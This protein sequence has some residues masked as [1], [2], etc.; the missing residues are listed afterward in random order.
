MGAVVESK[1]NDIH[2]PMVSK[3]VILINN[4]P[5]KRLIRLRSCWLM[6]VAGV[7]PHK[8]QQNSIFHENK[9]DL[10]CCNDGT[11]PLGDEE[12]TYNENLVENG[13]V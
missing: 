3:Q 7:S 4:Y 1:T 8:K 5:N 13:V 2:V 12:E 10:S 6:S 9:V 11:P